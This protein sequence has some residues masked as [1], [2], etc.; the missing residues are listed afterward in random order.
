MMSLEERLNVF[1]KRAPQVDPTAYVARSAE[2]IGDVSLGAGVSVWPRCV[3][4]A[5]LNSITI[6]QDS[7]LQEAV[8][9]HLSDDLPVVVGRRVTVGHQAMLHACTIQDDCL[10]G[11]QAILL[12]GCQIGAGS[13][14]GAGCLVTQHMRVPPR[15]LVLGVPGRVVGVVSD[16]QYESILHSAQRYVTLGAFYKAHAMA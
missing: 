13:I 6:G 11:M 5:D 9:V 7:N 10:I 15:S 2:L 12:D 14:V 4:R 16:A 8:V 1:L 3:L